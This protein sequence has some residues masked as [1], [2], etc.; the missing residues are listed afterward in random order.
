MVGT[1]HWTLYSSEYISL[2]LLWLS[3]QK[4]FYQTNVFILYTVS[5]LIFD[6]MYKKDKVRWFTTLKNRNEETVDL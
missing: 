2:Y 6:I 4:M 3:T 1:E 5:F